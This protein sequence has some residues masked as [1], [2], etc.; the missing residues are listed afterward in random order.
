MTGSRDD[1]ELAEL[2]ARLR[3]ADRTAAPPFG[4]VRRGGPGKAVGAG[5]AV[6]AVNLIRAALAV[7]AVI[8]LL[9]FRGHGGRDDPA[10][11]LAA[12]R[13]ITAWR[14]PTDFL[15]EVPG[16]RLLATVPELGVV[17]GWYPLAPVASSAPS[18]GGTRP[19]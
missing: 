12:A 4:R 11:A 18:K 9:L 2:F 15:L 6:E 5:R 19:L 17:K 14:S 13:R 10:A 3:Q 8:A 16:S 1:R 7:A